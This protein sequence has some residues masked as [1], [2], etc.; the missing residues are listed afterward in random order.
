MQAITDKQGNQKRAFCLA[1]LSERKPWI[2]GE[3]CH[4]FQTAVPVEGST[5]MKLD[6]P[7]R[8]EEETP[9]Q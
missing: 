5:E 2:G 8:V 6:K 1:C 9:T 3:L 4:H 7:I